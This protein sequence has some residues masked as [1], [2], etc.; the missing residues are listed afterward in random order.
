MRQAVAGM[1]WSKQFY[2]FDGDQWL[3]EHR[4]NPLQ[5]GSRE[6]RNREWFHMVRKTRYMIRTLNPEGPARSDSGD[7]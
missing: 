1:L 3:D 7:C 2:F 6:F 4:A 5:D